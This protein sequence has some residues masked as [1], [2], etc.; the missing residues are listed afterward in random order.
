M[1][2]NTELKKQVVEL[3]HKTGSDHHQ[4]FIETNGKEPE[5]WPLGYAEYLLD[6]LGPLLNT[7]FTKSELVYLI[8]TAD[9]ERAVKAPSSDWPVYYADFFTQKYT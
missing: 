7:R 4:A 3:F 8:L 1:M 6:K 2:S 9:N 5:W